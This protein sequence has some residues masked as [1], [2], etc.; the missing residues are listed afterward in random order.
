MQRSLYVAL[1]LLLLLCA[2]LAA[3]PQQEILQFHGRYAD[4]QHTVFLDACRTATFFATG[5]GGNSS[6]AAG[7]PAQHDPPGAFAYVEIYDACTGELYYGFGGSELG[8]TVDIHNLKSA[9]FTVPLELFHRTCGISPE[10]FEYCDEASVGLVVLYV[11]LLGDGAMYN[12]SEVTRWQTERYHQLIRR[13]G[14]QR[15][16]TI[17]NATLFFEGTDLLADYM[18]ADA[19]STTGHAV[20]GRDGSSVVTITKL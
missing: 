8:G 16:S 17:V 14:V 13:H 9:S 4:T 18:E 1:A 6:H 19:A 20:I 7:Q 2:P 15:E 12:D 11:D 3:Q 5:G 10:G